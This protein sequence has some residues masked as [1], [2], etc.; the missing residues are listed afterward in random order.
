[1]SWERL[2]TPLNI[3]VIKVFVISVSWMGEWASLNEICFDSKYLCTSHWWSLQLTNAE[4]YS[5]MPK[6]K[7]TSGFISPFLFQLLD[8][9]STLLEIRDDEKEQEK[10]LDYLN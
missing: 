6:L 2:M 5:L 7:G 1:M 9:Q 10:H 8:L 4:V 3:L